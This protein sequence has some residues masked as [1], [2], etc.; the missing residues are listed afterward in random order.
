M[1]QIR[2]QGE[3]QD[4]PEIEV[5]CKMNS[6]SRGSLRGNL[7]SLT[8]L[9]FFAALLVI[10]QHYTFKEEVFP[11]QLFLGY[12][13]VSFFFVLSGFILTYAHA[14]SMPTANLEIGSRKFWT[15]R[16]A[17]ILPVYCFALFVA[18]PWYFYYLVT[19]AI[20]PSE[21]GIGA[22][23]VV[24]LL[25]SWFPNFAL[26]W[27]PPAWSLSVEA[28]FY[29]A[30]PLIW[31]CIRHFGDRY[32]LVFA[33]LL[34]ISVS[35][36]RQAFLDTGNE[37]L[38][39]TRLSL[40][41]PL[42]HLPQFI[43][44]ISL[45]RIFLYQ[46][47]IS[48]KYSSSVLVAS[49]FC[50]VLLVLFRDSAPSLQNGAVVAIICGALIFGFARP[51]VLMGWRPLSG[52][53]LN[54]LGQASYGMYILHYPLLLWYRQL[55]RTTDLVPPYWLDFALYLGFVVA[56]A[57]LSFRFL[58]TPAR[59]LFGQSKPRQPRAAGQS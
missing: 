4:D 58:E 51:P 42:L 43:F 27:N 7:R 15:A 47:E 25:Q 1:S 11:S 57:I 32:I 26:Y 54:L 44:G 41:F 14:P 20:S 9:R 52:K 45:G 3:L 37:D 18:L 17:R 59:R 13:A 46:E 34:I 38:V 8:A 36:L 39:I 31:R 50:L 33:V 16:A 55:L 35:A 12:E 21:F 10:I 19:G 53:V 49:L 22:F 56:V 30:Y 5:S 24:T 29:L 40:Y 2:G 28:L 48:H 23:L 6:E